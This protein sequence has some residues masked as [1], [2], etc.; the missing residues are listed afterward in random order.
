MS[1]V[2][3]CYAQEQI[4]ITTY[5]PAPVGVYTELRA[6]RMAIGATWF[7]PTN[8]VWGAQIEATADLVV[9]GLVGIGTRTPATAGSS[10]LEVSSGT[11]GDAYIIIEADEDNSD[12]NDNPKLSFRQDNNGVNAIIGLAGVAGNTPF[13]GT[14]ENAFLI[15][16]EDDNPALQFATN[17]FVRM[18]IETDGDIGIGTTTPMADFDVRGSSN[19]CIR[20]DYD[21]SSGTKSCP[22]SYNMAVPNFVYQ[23]DSGDIITKTPALPGFFLCCKSCTDSST[24]P[25]GICG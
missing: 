6:Q 3:I 12:E 17:D 9:E 15:G 19:V 24:P 14:L 7:N 22:A 13:T 8:H 1:F 16:S 10:V 2:T 21:G 11:S 5:Y 18:T 4:T 25:D 20:V 23:D